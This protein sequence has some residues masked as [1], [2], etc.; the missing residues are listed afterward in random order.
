MPIADYVKEPGML[1]GSS[2]WT[3]CADCIGATA[4]SLAH[5]Q[6]IVEIRTNAQLF[7]QSCIGTGF[8]FRSHDEVGTSK[9]QRLS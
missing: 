6:V 2:G 7:A 9:W 3:Q 5:A 1:R 8:A 4:L